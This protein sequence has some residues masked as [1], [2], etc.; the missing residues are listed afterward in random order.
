MSPEP[1]K[2]L[3]EDIRLIREKVSFALK[4]TM[5]LSV[6]TESSGC[7]TTGVHSGGLVVVIGTRKYGISI[8]PL[9][10]P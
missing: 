7:S 4:G 6:W 10:G 2:G 3:P 1:A 9:E 8:E 5:G